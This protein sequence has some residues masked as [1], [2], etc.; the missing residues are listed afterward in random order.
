MIVLVLIAA[1]EGFSSCEK[2]SFAPPSVD[3]N[4]TWH[5]QADI[6]PIFTANCITC[7]NGRQNPDLRDGKSYKSLTNNKFI[8]SPAATSVIFTTI[9]G[10][11][12]TARSSATD[13]LKIFYW[14]NQGA[15]NN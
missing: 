8:T 13:K 9:S 7:H 11:E 3:A 1:V 12:H 6:Q 15:L 4:A 2:V 14:I 5:F 10:S